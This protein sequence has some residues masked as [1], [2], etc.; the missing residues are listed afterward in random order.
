MQ[1]PAVVEEAAA[2]EIETRTRS[3]APVAL[4]T[5]A[6]D[7]ATD[8]W[9]EPSQENRA[10][11]RSGRWA[12]VVVGF[13]A[14]AVV[15][16]GVAPS[17][18]RAMTAAA[19]RVAMSVVT[20]VAPEAPPPPPAPSPA[21]APPPPEP[22]PPPPEPTEPDVGAPALGPSAAPVEARPAEPAMDSRALTNDATRALEHGDVARAIDLATSATD[23]DPASAVA[24]LTLGA[25][26]YVQGQHGNERWALQRCVET[27][28]IGGHP[29]TPGASARVAEC[30]ALLRR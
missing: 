19:P 28:S 26:F 18:R 3:D 23:A 21:P 30:R 1:L 5:T 12:S 22:T 8:T 10:P 11:R 15:V 13:A 27:A 20:E 9:I 25:A 29:Q 7:A 2:Q 24:W 16:V 17:L 6:S 14:V 4:D